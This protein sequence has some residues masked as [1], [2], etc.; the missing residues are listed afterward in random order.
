[1]NYNIVRVFEHKNRQIISFIIVE[2]NIIVCFNIQLSFFY[3]I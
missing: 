3:K 1:M 2:I